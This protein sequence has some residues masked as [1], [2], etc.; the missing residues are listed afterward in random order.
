MARQ[1]APDAC[2]KAFS[3]LGKGAPARF[4]ALLPDDVSFRQVAK[5]RGGGD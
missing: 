1:H 5:R 2:Q 4:R 3:G